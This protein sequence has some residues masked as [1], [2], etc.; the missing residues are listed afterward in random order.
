VP[1]DWTQALH[2]QNIARNIPYMCLFGYL[3]KEEGP[4]TIKAINAI[5]IASK[6]LLNT[7][8]IIF[9]LNQA[10]QIN[11][12]S[13]KRNHRSLILVNLMLL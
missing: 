7:H 13:K 6:D 1:T 9:F 10:K 2:W 4:K 8:I 12:F 11:L 5:E 3:L